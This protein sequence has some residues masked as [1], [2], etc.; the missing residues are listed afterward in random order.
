M[1]RILLATPSFITKQEALAPMV[2][3]TVSIKNKALGITSIKMAIPKKSQNGITEIWKAGTMS[4]IKMVPA[5][6]ALA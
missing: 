4:S 5:L 2:T 1:A 3:S 6:E